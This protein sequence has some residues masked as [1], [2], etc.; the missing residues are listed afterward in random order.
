[1]NK[2]TCVIYL[3]LVSHAAAA[4]YVTAQTKDQKFEEAE[5]IFVGKLLKAELAEENP[6][7]MRLKLTYEVKE[8]FKGELNDKEIVYTAID[9]AACGLGASGFYGDQV[10]FTGPDSQTGVP[11]S[12]TLDESWAPDGFKYSKES[13]EWLKFLRGK[14]L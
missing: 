6:F 8:G 3:L 12:F 1:M 14:K 2:I 4:C 9:F 11:P 5:K 13:L 7:Y 10:I